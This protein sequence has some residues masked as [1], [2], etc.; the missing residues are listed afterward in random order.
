MFFHR[1]EVLE[2]VVEKCGERRGER[3][4]CQWYP[5]IDV[6]VMNN[7]HLIVVTAAEAILEKRESVS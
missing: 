6:A 2:V 7:L 5:T 1:G 4:V 3:S